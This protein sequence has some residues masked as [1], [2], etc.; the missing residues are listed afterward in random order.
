MSY[1]DIFLTTKIITDETFRLHEGFDM[2]LLDDKTMPPSQL[3]TLT[4]LKTEP[5]LNFKSRLAQS[6]G[7]SLNYFRLWTLAP[8]RHHQRETTTR[9]NKAVPENDPELTMHNV[10]CKIASGAQNLILYLEVLDPVH[11][12]LFVHLKENHKMVFLKH[13][14]A[15]NQKL[16]GIGHFYVQSRGCLNP[17]IKNHMKLPPNTNLQLYKELGPGKTN[18]EKP[19]TGYSYDRSIQNGDIFCFQ[20]E[21]SDQ[22]IAELKR[23][24]LYVDV[25]EFYNFLDNRVLVH[26][27][28]RHE[29]MSATIE[30]SLVLSKKDTYE[31]MSKLVS[32]KLNHSPENL[33]FTGSLKGFPQNVIHGQRVPSTCWTSSQKVITVADMIETPNQ[34]SGYP[35]YSSSD[36]NNILFYE[37][38]DLP[39]GEV[40]QKRML[41]VTWTGADNREEGKYSLL[42][43]KTS[44]MNAVADKLSTMVTFSKN[45]SRKIK[46][47]TIKDGKIQVHFT[48][49]E[50]LKDIL[51]V[52]NIYAAEVSTMTVKQYDPAA[53]LKMLEFVTKLNV[54]G[55]NYQQWLKALE[56]VLGMATGKAGILT[57]PG[58]TIGAAED[59]MIKQA[60]TASVDSALVS[61]VLEAESGM[62]AFAEIQ[63]LYTLK[64]R[65]GH[66][67]LMKEILQTKFDMNDGTVGVESHFRRVEDLV[68]TLFESGFQLTPESFKGLLFHLSLPE[69]DAQPFVNICK[70]IDERPGGACTVSNK[71]LVQIAQAELAH[72]RQRRQSTL[73]GPSKST[74][75]GPTT[76]RET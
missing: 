29:A 32:A 10:N 53:M 14:D 3:L 44:S 2:A 56:S 39:T 62:V 19:T 7:Y 54:D 38:L 45:S 8:Q 21:P 20:A 18:V 67:R 57:S 23:K 30:F 35:S 5:F 49:E 76:N 63:K 61:T 70:R 4:V 6:L 24:K 41:K 16:V 69:L 25:V 75:K 72:F 12:A 50:I 66:I 28:P 11:E 52:E 74:V 40:Q 27:K 73:S 46:L 13:F 58:H 1:H 17:L 59:L 60:I 9:L 37:L 64:S 31:Q 55:R 68:E 42:M 71:E 65:S 47:F 36:L 33:R 48:G 26:F 15:L 34:N 51:D 22:D 43:P